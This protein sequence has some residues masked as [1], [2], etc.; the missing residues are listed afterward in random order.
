MA[1]EYRLKTLFE[2]PATDLKTLKQLKISKNRIEHPKFY[3]T[4]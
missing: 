2:L 3:N 1:L 4:A